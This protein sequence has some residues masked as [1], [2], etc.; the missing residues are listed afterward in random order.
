MVNSQNRNEAMDLICEVFEK[1]HKRK[2]GWSSFDDGSI[3]FFLD[4]NDPE[5]DT[6]V[7]ALVPHLWEKHPLDDVYAAV[8]YQAKRYL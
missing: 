6:H 1:T 8:E 5:G 3:H 7:A 2:L 4:E